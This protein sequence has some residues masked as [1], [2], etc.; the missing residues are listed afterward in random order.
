M[1]FEI[2]YNSRFVK[3]MVPSG[4]AASQTPRILEG[5]VPRILCTLGVCAPQTPC[6]LGA[7]RPTICT[8]WPAPRKHCNGFAP[9]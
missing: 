7:A 8:V 6:T 4:F 9:W 5:C 1:S 3:L 2:F